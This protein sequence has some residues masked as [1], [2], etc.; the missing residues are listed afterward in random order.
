MGRWTTA[1]YV[2]A[3]APALDGASWHRRIPANGLDGVRVNKRYTL[4]TRSETAPVTSEERP[5]MPLNVS[6]EVAYQPPAYALHAL[7][8][9]ESAG[10]EAWIVGGWVR[11]ALL[12]APCHDVDITTSALW[13]QSARLFAEAGCAVHETGIKHGTITVV[14]EG[15]PIEVTTYRVEGVYSDHRH[16]DSVRYVRKVTDDLA[17]R[18][19][20]IN[21][22][23]Y[24]PQR[25]LLDPYGGAEDLAQGLVR[26]VGRPADRFYEDALRVLRAVRFACR[27]GFRMEE[28]THAALVAAAPGLDNIAQERIGQELCGILRTGR[29]GWALLHEPEVMCAALPELEPMY[30]FDQLSIWHVYD[31]LEHTVHV[32]NAIEAFTAGVASLRLR[33]AALLHDVGKPACCVIDDMGRGH[34][35]GHPIE[36]A[37]MS[38]RILRRLGLPGEL[39]RST[40]T[41]IRYHDHVVRPT[42]RSMR[43]TLAILGEA[44]HG[45]ALVLAHELMDLKRADAVSKQPKCAAYAIELDAMDRILDEEKHKGAPLRVSDLAVGGKEV[46]ELL[47]GKPGPMVGM[48]LST[49]LQAVVDNEVEN[50]REALM[51]ELW[52]MLQEQE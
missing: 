12:G 28:S 35:Y 50:T 14:V 51:G 21:A 39:V 38:E 16:P 27:M 43:R 42:A 10:Y 19:F 18:D 23:A 15:H 52:R 30:G 8:I 37:E 9:L 33:W 48:I 26:A 41:L 46:L 22:M 32:C 1:W 45:N 20:T 11:D 31:V 47:G 4:A 36:G 13:N 3:V 5:L 40:C 25:G 29:V 17:R 44:N 7:E 24:H 49:L 2:R 34:F 6:H